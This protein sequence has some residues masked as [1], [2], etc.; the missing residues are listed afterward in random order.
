M[1]ILH[2]VTRCR[3]QQ[4]CAG[5]RWEC[6][7]KM[8]GKLEKRHA[9]HIAGYGEGNERRLTGKHETSSMDAFRCHAA[10]P[11]LHPCPVASTQSLTRSL[12][13]M[14]W[15]T[16]QHRMPVMD[17]S[18]SSTTHSCLKMAFN[19]AGVALTLLHINCTDALPDWQAKYIRYGCLVICRRAAAHDALTRHYTL[20]AS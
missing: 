9:V 6:I 20:L 7:Q 2:I 14:L 12:Q 17:S 11:L 3:Q 13:A 18:R 8:I 5:C 4:M 1:A 15:L 16:G 19:I 10:H